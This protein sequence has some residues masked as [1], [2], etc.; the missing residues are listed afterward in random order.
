MEELAKVVYDSLL[1]LGAKDDQAKQIMSSLQQEHIE[2]LTKVYQ[3]SSGDKKAMTEATAQV[4][5]AIQKAYHGAKLAYI[6]RLN[7]KT[8]RF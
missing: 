2:Y 1:Q 4:V 5:Q 8:T 6:N 7:G 3:Q